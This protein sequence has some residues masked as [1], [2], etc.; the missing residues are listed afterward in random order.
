MRIESMFNHTNILG[1][2]MQ[3]TAMRD[4]VIAHNI[5][6]ADTPG[7]KRNVLLFEDSLA[8]AVSNF[9]NTGRLDLSGVRPRIELEFDW[10][11]YRIDENNVDIEFEMA[12]LYQNSVRFDVMAL[13]IM[14]HYRILNV[15]IQAL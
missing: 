12:Q 10:L 13:G 3:A 9:R 14:N 4:G 7:F 2:A 6:N 15:A 11:N 8:A 1:A 5:A